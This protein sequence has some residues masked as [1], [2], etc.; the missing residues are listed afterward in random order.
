ML[1]VMNMKCVVF[2]DS[3]DMYNSLIKYICNCSY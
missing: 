1:N 2:I 3:V